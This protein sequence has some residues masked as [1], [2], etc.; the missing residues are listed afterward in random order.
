MSKEHTRSPRYENVPLHI[1]CLRPYL[2]SSLFIL[3]DIHYLSIKSGNFV[4]LY[5]NWSFGLLEGIKE[6]Y[7]I[8]CNVWREEN[9]INE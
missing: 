9:L 5:E 7:E 8:F 2:C 3:E 1:G 4:P 6:S